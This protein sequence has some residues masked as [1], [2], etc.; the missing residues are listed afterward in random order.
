MYTRE[1]RRKYNEEN[2]DAVRAYQ[3]KYYDTHREE[4]L[5]QQRESRKRNPLVHKN[6]KIKSLLKSGFDPASYQ[7]DRRNILRNKILVALG[8][9]CVRCGFTDVRALQVDHV[10]GDGAG[11][12]RQL[13]YNA[14][15]S[16]I[17]REIESG[18]SRYQLLCANCNWIKRHEKGE[19]T[20]R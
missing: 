4:I 1:E 7:K 16:K 9:V 15:Y 13:G 11:H 14:H 6:Y 8:C 2:K 20:K 19:H 3:K 10:N 18:S 12:R 5:S 17:L